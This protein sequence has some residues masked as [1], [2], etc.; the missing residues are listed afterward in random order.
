MTENEILAEIDKA[1]GFYE[2]N[3]YNVQ[4]F[5]AHIL[6][7]I[8]DNF[9]PPI[10]KH[11]ETLERLIRDITDLRSKQDKYFA[12]KNK[13]VLLECKKAQS[14]LDLKLKHLLSQ[15]Y[16]ISRFKDQAPPQGEIKF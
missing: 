7:M 1:L 11:K 9:L 14:A 5:Q 3:V 6:T 15:G 4:D 8:R 13:S 10:A 12:T 2:G 16:T